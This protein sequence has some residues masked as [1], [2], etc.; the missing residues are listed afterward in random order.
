MN[1]PYI[2]H[3]IFYNCKIAEL[4]QYVIYF[5]IFLAKNACTAYSLRI[6]ASLIQT[7]NILQK[8]QTF[9]NIPIKTLKTHHSRTHNKNTSSLKFFQPAT[10]SVASE[11]WHNKTVSHTPKKV[12]QNKL[13]V[14]FLAF[15]AEVN[16][17]HKIPSR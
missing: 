6:T 14:N 7:I 10:M 9:Y 4:K 5:T 11:W 13:Y 12:V 3:K 2:S 8:Q 15:N 1:N 16:C 17:I